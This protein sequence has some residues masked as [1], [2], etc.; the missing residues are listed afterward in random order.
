MLE[1]KTAELEVLMRWV[2]AHDGWHCYRVEGMKMLQEFY[3][4]DKL[5]L[6]FNDLVKGEDNFYLL[7]ATKQ[8]KQEVSMV[9]DRTNRGKPAVDAK[10]L[11]SQATIRTMVNEITAK[12]QASAQA[13]EWSVWAGCIV[14]GPGEGPRLDQVFISGTNKDNAVGAQTKFKKGLAEYDNA[15]Q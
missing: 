3:Q 4:C 11:D 9:E 5:P 14:A 6:L 12:M 8:K 7:T 10:T 2:P 15:I 1:N 13:G